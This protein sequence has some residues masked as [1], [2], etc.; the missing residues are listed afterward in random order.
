MW[1]LAHDVVALGDGDRALQLGADGE[2]GAVARSN[3]SGSGSGA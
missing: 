1:W 2:H 3:G